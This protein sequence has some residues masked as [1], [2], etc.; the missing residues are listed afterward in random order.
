MRGVKTYRIEEGAIVKRQLINWAQKFKH[1]SV[2]ESNALNAVKVPI[3]DPYSGLHCLVAVGAYSEIVGTGTNDFERLKRYVDSTNDW[4]FGYLT[5][6]LKNQIESMDS[7]NPDFQKHPDLHFFQPELVV[8]ASESSLKFHYLEEVYDEEKLNLTL[9]EILES[10]LEEA[11]CQPDT[12]T[13]EKII[14]VRARLSKTAYL[15][16]V[17]ALKKHISYGDIYEVNYCQEFFASNI[18][19]EPLRIFERLNQISKA[20]FAAFYRS[21]A[22]YLISASPERFLRKMGTSL[23]SQ[24][25]KGTR[26]RDENEE[27]DLILK[28][29]LANSIKEQS[30][31]VMIVDLVRNDLSRSAVKGTVEVEDLFG[32]YSFEQVHQMISTVKCELRKDIHPIDAIKNAFPMGSMTGAPKIRAMQL[33]EE[34]EVTKRGL[35]SG[36]V[37]Y[38]TP[39]QDFDFS[40]IIR[41]VLYNEDAKYLSLMVGGAITDLADPSAEYEECLVKAK[42]MFDAL[43]VKEPVS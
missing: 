29:E 17:T 7:N 23:I 33:I 15:E 1:F 24:P 42:A 3:N 13:S 28:E 38:I 14:E 34:Y 36:A 32:I 20:P 11:Y 6:D 22:R 43:N 27:M 18:E 35:Y 31:N 41:S 21:G 19:V 8:E 40:V 25:I 37:G 39:D 9:K 26:R 2:L 5:Y 10:E 30:E 4:L 12:L 16:A